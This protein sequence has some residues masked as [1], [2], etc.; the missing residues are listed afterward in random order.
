L[1]DG[2]VILDFG[3]PWFT[4]YDPNDPSNDKWGTVI[5]NLGRGTHG[6]DSARIKQSVELFAQG[7]V[8]EAS[9]GLP[10]WPHIVLA[11]GT[12]NYINYRYAPTSYEVFTVAQYRRHGEHWGNMAAEIANELNDYSPW[13]AI[14]GANDI[15]FNWND[16]AH[17][18]AWI[19]GFASIS[20]SDPYPRGLYYYNYGSCDGCHISNDP[21]DVV[22]YYNAFLGKW[23]TWKWYREDVVKVSWANPSAFPFPQIYY[24]SPPECLAGCLPDYYQARQWRGISEYS[25][26]NLIDGHSYGKMD[27][28]GPLSGRSNPYPTP[29]SAMT[30]EDSWA[31]L[32]NW[33]NSDC[34]TTDT[35]IPWLTN[36]SQG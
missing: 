5:A 33:L 22:E 17:T 4:N 19:D 15:E 25:A 1:L 11:V 26:S 6:I 10:P 13:V 18:Y 2:I 14:E 35:Y 23:F 16:P 28:L 29:D 20:V 8:K 7:F 21:V 32:W 24:P 31:S 27:F 36:I 12:T 3:K 9:Q 30:P 34:C